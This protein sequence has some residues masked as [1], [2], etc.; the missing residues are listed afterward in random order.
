MAGEQLLFKRSCPHASRLVQ[1]QAERVPEPFLLWR[2]QLA[3]CQSPEIECVWQI[4]PTT[5]RRVV[6]SFSYLLAQPV[7]LSGLQDLLTFHW[8]SDIEAFDGNAL[9]FSIR[10][11][12]AGNYTY[13]NWR[14]SW[15]RKHTTVVG[16]GFGGRLFLLRNVLMSVKHTLSASPKGTTITLTIRSMSRICRFLPACFS[17]MEAAIFFRKLTWLGLSCL[18]CR[19]A[20]E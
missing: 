10:R 2:W 5:Q 15:D 17:F 14:P 16:L 9:K 13:E 19:L 6:C 11:I 7:E 4:A 3:K 1:V 20:P 18:I 12:A 8:G